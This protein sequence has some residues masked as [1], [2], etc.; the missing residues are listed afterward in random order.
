PTPLVL[1][2]GQVGNDFVERDAF[3]EVD[4]RRMYGQMA[5]WVAQIDRADRVPEY[6]SRAF[7][8]AVSGRPGPVVL[9]LPGGMLTGPATVSDTG[10]YQRVAAHPG[11]AD[12]QKLRIMIAQARRPF[13]LAGGSDW[14]AQAC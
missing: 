9:A 4:F 5:K 11:E 6:V 8:T 3:Q 2:I 12:L 14:D 1:F 7:H 10:R 13:V